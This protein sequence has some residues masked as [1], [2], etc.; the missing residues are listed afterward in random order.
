MAY[1]QQLAEV[2]ATQMLHKEKLRRLCTL[3]NLKLRKVE[4]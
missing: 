2:E 1:L 4:G 3:P